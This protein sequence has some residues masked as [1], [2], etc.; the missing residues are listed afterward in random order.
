MAACPFAPSM[1]AQ[2]QT[3]PRTAGRERAADASLSNTHSASQLSAGQTTAPS[4]CG[5]LESS[6]EP[7]SLR[8]AVSVSKFLQRQQAGRALEAQRRHVPHAT[9]DGWTRGPTKTAEFAFA[10]GGESREGEREG[11][12]AH[13]SALKQVR[14]AR[15]RAAGLRWGAMG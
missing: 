11:L 3:T 12:R 7:I 5:G 9:G 15:T 10:T 2:A 14:R 1:Q 8:S 6:S 4:P 13:L